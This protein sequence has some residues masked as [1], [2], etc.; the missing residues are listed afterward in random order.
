M[1]LRLKLVLGCT[2]GCGTILIFPNVLPLDMYLV[3]KTQKLDPTFSRGVSLTFG[4][5]N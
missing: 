5:G 3:T 2:M 1:G 4:K